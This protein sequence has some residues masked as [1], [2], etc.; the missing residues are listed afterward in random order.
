MTGASSG[1][2]EQFARRY[3]R[4]GY[5]LVVVARSADAL[6]ALAEELT[7]QHPINV[8]VHVADLSD[9][10]DVAA[11]VHRITPEVPRVDHLVNC[12]GV[13]PE[14][15][16]AHT[17]ER[18]LRQMVELNVTALTLLTRAAIIRMR[19][20]RT[21]TIVNIA[22]AAAHQP[23][24][25]LAAYAASKSYVLMLTEA[26]SEENRGHGLRIFA[27]SPGD[28]ET[29]MNPGPT[30]NKRRPEQVVDTTWTA[31]SSRSPSVVDG[32]SNSI[33]A[34]LSSRFFPKRLGLRLAERML[35]GKARPA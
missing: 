22:S 33:L 4:E 35:R 30:R 10:A 17:D 3:A 29:R 14:G 7:A 20:A 11:L 2:G 23:M 16:L 19:E 1:I 9:A 8:D 6:Q 24:P 12:A 13:S 31:F 34:T 27:V 32:R 21:G 28:T 15:D 5:D 25:H 26:L 18:E